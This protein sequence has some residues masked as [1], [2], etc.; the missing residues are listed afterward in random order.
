MSMQ[1][2][3]NIPTRAYVYYNNLLTN[4]NYFY[5]HDYNAIHA[6]QVATIMCAG[7]YINTIFRCSLRMFDRI[8]R[9]RLET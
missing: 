7:L 9:R 5:C 6:E 1:T 4:D 3:I 8:I 2:N